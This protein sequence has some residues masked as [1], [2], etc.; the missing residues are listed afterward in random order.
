[1]MA[2]P[3]VP[4]ATFSN[5][6]IGSSMILFTIPHVSDS[7]AISCSRERL[8]IWR[9]I[10]FISERRVVSRRFFSDIAIGMRSISYSPGGREG[11]SLSF[12]PILD[13]SSYSGRTS[14]LASRTPTT[15][16]PAGQSCEIRLQSSK[17]GSS[18]PIQACVKVFTAR[19][20]HSTPNRRE[21]LPDGPPVGLALALALE[22]FSSSS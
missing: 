3:S 12:F 2:E 16:L 6:L 1:M 14:T 20:H 4:Q 18:A 17:D 5:L 15:K 8:P 21:T 11:T 22:L 10:R 7:I 13:F 19:T 9:R